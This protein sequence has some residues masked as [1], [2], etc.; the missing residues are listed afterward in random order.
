MATKRLYISADIEGVAG[1]VTPE[2]LGPQGFEYQKAREWMTGEVLAACRAAFNAGIDEIVISDSHGNGQN[3]LLDEFP[4]NVRIVRSWPRPLCMMEGVQD[5]P[6]VGAFLIGYHAGA[7]NIGGVLS[8]TMSSKGIR[9]IKLNGKEAS[10]TV[11]SAWTAAHYGVP[12]LLATGDNVYIDHVNDLLHTATHPTLAAI[13]KRAASFTSA[14]SLTPTQ[15]RMEITR[16]AE[17]ALDM[18][19]QFTAPTAIA[20][21][22]VRVECLR[23]QSAELLAYLPMFQQ[24]DSHTVC[25]QADDIVQTS[26]C[27]GFMLASG[28][29]A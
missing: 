16:Q 14:A 22:E 6:Y 7:G 19:D 11:I 24:T 10:E 28:A 26:E 9:R 3:L 2:Q 4:D 29:L 1:V 23:R 12:V 17:A 13:T 8:H 21:I 20:N 27:L 18:A 15:A 5:G 25:F